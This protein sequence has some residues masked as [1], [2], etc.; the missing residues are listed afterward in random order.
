MKIVD[1]LWK[2]NRNKIEIWRHILLK[3][4]HDYSYDGI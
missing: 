2:R 3:Q 1:I 4:S